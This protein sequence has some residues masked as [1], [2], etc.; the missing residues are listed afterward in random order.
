MFVVRIT[1]EFAEIC[2][3]RCRL[4]Y[5]SSGSVFGR[6]EQVLHHTFLLVGGQVASMK[7]SVPAREGEMH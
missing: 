7:C 6:L 5:W 3:W 2:T 1:K 4:L